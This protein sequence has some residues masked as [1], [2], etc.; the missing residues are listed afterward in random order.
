MA[1]RAVARS[2]HD[3]AIRALSAPPAFETGIDQAQRHARFLVEIIRELLPQPRPQS[4][5]SA[6]PR[7]YFVSPARAV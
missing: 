2:T 6:A 4:R 1:R 5:H 3:A 7:N